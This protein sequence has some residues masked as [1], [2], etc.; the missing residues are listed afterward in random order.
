MMMMMMMMIIHRRGVT[1]LAMDD[2]DH[3][4]YPLP[5]CELSD[6]R[7]MSMPTVVQFEL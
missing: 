7:E 5:N 3:V 2:T 6:E 1:T 4:V